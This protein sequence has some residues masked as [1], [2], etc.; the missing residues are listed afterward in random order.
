MLALLSGCAGDK[1]GEDTARDTARDVRPTATYTIEGQAVEFGPEEAPAAE[2]LCVEAVDPSVMLDGAGSAP[3]GSTTV[4]AE[5]AYTLTDIPIRELPTVVRIRDCED[6]GRPT[7]FPTSSPVQLSTDAPV[8]AGDVLRDVRSIVLGVDPF[9]RMRT[10]LSA[11][12]STVDLTE[13]GLVFGYVWTGEGRPIA[14][15]QVTCDGCTAYYGDADDSDGL[16][17]TGGVVN[18]ATGDAGVWVIP[19]A[20]RG[21]Y[22]AVAAGYTFAAVPMAAPP[23]GALFGVLLGE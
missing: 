20:P 13:S 2:G 7:V 8:A 21:D 1:G 15:A 19:G 9:D 11:A 3:L 22:G 6:T 18:T 12:G 23:G 10:D 14:G 16:F 5:G 4:G 17:M